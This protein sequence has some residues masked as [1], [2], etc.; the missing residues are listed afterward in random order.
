MIYTLLFSFEFRRQGHPSGFAGRGGFNWFFKY[1]LMPLQPETIANPAKPFETP[2]M[3]GGLFAIWAKYF[4]V[5][6]GGAEC[7]DS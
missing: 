5:S 2:I 3:A 7:S 4:K 1:K 6:F